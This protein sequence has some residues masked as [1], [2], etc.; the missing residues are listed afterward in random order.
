MLGPLE[1]SDDASSFHPV[2]PALFLP[3]TQ[4]A[5]LGAVPRPLAPSWPFVGCPG[6]SGIK[7]RAP[8]ALVWSLSQ[9]RCLW[10]KACPAPSPLSWRQIIDA[11]AAFKSQRECWTRACHM[12]L[13]VS[14]QDPICGHCLPAHFLWASG[15]P[16]SMTP[17]AG[18]ASRRCPGRCTQPGPCRAPSLGTCTQFS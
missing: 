16:W 2:Y 3:P 18:S 13:E 12:A 4:T 5:A 7:S 1:S 8:Q 17:R 15:S 9:P 6:N 14:G 10:F 11:A